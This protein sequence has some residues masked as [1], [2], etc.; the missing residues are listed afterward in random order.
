MIDSYQIH[1]KNY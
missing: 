1:T